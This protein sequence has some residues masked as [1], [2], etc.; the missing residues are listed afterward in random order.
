VPTLDNHQSSDFTKPRRIKGTLEERFKNYCG[1]QDP[2]TGCIPWL[3]SKNKQGYGQIQ[4]DNPRMRRPLLAH[5]VAWKLAGNILLPNRVILHRCNNPA[6]VN[7]EHLKQGTQLENMQ[8]AG[9]D[10]LMRG[11]RRFTKADYDYV[12]QQVAAG[13]LKG[14]VARALGCAPSMVTK[15]IQ[16]K[17]KNADS[18]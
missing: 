15:I 4:N 1:P 14:D 8:Q 10:E 17:L 7:V 11:P 3:A 6:C 12:K 2:E 5:R 9:Q 18:R 16:G 13:Y